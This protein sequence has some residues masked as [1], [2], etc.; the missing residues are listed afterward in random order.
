MAS[1]SSLAKLLLV[2]A[3]CAV[4]AA[5][6][7]ANISSPGEIG[8]IDNGGGSGGGSGG[9]G[10][11]GG[12]GGDGGGD[13]DADCPDGTT[14]GDSVS[15]AAT[16]EISG[17]IIDD[18]TLTA[19]PLY[20]LSGRVDVG[21]DVGGGGDF[22]DGDEATLTVE[23][24]V[25]IFGASGSDFLVVNRGSR[26][27]ADGDA[28]NPIVFTALQDVEGTVGEEDRGLWGG[29]VIL[30]RAPIS[31]CSGFTPG[32]PE[33]E[34]TVEGTDALYGGNAPDDDSGV[35]NYVQVLFAGNAISADNELNAIT[36]GGVGSGTEIDFVQTHNN[37]DDGIEWF[38]GTVD[39]K[40]AV[41][42]GIGDDSLDWA[43]G[44]TGK[45][46]FGIVVQSD[47]AG[48]RGI[49]AGNSSLPPGLADLRSNPT[50]S[51]LTFLGDPA[52]DE[53]IV[54]R[55]GTDG[56]IVNSVIVG[57]SECLDIDA[58]ETFAA[59]PTFN[60]VL[61]DCPT[62]FKDDGPGDT[63]AD[64]EAIFNDD[65]NNVT[66][67][68]AS[69]SDR[70]F[71]GPVE[72]DVEAF[73]VTALD[74]FFDDVDY[75][76]AFSPDETV[77]NNW[78]AG[79][80]FALFDEPECPEGT[81]NEGTLNGLNR[82]G[83]TGVI[84]GDL[85]LTRGNIYELQGRVDVGV[86]VGGGGDFADG[87]PATLTIESGVTVFGESGSDFLVV[88]RG[89]QLFVNG[90]ADDPVIM[91]SLQ[92][93]NGTQQPE[94]RGQWGG[95]VIL[96]RAPISSCSGFTPGDPECENTVE[97][98]DALYGGNAPDDDSGVL[99]YVQVL[100]AGNAISADNELNAI[101]LGGVG[102]GT[103][104]DF[105]QTHNNLDDGIEWFGGTVDVKHAVF[106]GIGDDSLD[107]AEGWTGKLQ[108]GIVVQSDAAGGRGIE[109]GN[110]SLPP[111]LADLR[112]NP[113]LS[114]LT[115]LGDP[116]ND[117]GIV[118]RGGTDGRIVN[119]VI[120]GFSECLDIDASETFAADP[121]F[122]SVLLD[123]PT[124]FK[125]DGP[126]D[127]AADVEAIFNDDP[128]N[129][130]DEANTLQDTFVNGSTENGVTAFDPTTL[131]AF[132]DAVDHIGAVKDGDDDWWRGWTCGLESGSDC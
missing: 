22:A 97:G 110:S 130:T 116:A 87:D 15:G 99:N 83:V 21:V 24:G 125:D 5:C 34:N 60:S 105:V 2:G 79:W 20:R 119:S 112:S 7:E 55:G 33:C 70:F 3:S 8:Q 52:N 42:T 124:T 13:G 82:C 48:G 44:W 29:V 62:T 64:V 39:V 12:D 77:S 61:L 40:H 111:G 100:F 129:V 1:Y 94:D 114:N 121:T 28:D 71:P 75:I 63:A 6:S 45:L 67:E 43:E 47:A 81:T 86:D 117:E 89:S 113:T 18:V 19:G 41:F 31:S 80:T 102:S 127:T 78:A 50:L 73:D 30:G 4:I 10:G 131:D 9:G 88:N 26:L 58:S 120:V 115:F 51:N 46:Q 85:R 37:L 57:F 84:T 56:R 66:D 25:T 106:T 11:G 122:N 108:F 101:T 104:I 36:L 53:G 59:D 32:D 123:C 23:P 107:W 54:L 38:G 90:T 72:E 69:L 103:E 49:E 118:L 93:V 98:T 92:D 128:N 68:P 14:P 95:M 74:P 109:A 132:F 76:G 91:T 17:A 65:P 126:G 16:C 35:L 27:V 96:G